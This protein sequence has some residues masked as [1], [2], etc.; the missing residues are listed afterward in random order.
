MNLDKALPLRIDGRSDEGRYLQHAV[1][2]F[3]FNPVGVR[4]PERAA[5]L[6]TASPSPSFETRPISWSPPASPVESRHHPH[7]LTRVSSQQLLRDQSDADSTYTSFPQSSR[8]TENLRLNLSSQARSRIQARAQIVSG[9]VSPVRNGSAAPI[10]S[11]PSRAGGGLRDGTV[12]D[13]YAT[14]HLAMETAMI[15]RNSDVG[16]DVEGESEEEL[17]DF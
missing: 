9:G 11:S 16:R 5:N 15:P 13:R 2:H 3:A 14:R 10:S 7:E 17:K 12:S 6:H 4:T 1:P 8:S